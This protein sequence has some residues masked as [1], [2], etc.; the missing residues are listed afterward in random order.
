MSFQDPAVIHLLD[1]P[2]EILE[3][4]ISFTKLDYMR[5]ILRFVCKRFSKFIP[6]TRILPNKEMKDKYDTLKYF[7]NELEYSRIDG[8]IYQIMDK[9]K[10][11]YTVRLCKVNFISWLL[12]Q[13]FQRNVVLKKT[14]TDIGWIIKKRQLTMST[15]RFHNKDPNEYIKKDKSYLANPT[16]GDIYI[17]PSIQKDKSFLANTTKCETSCI[18]PSIQKYKN[19]QT[20]WLINFENN[21]FHYDTIYN[22]KKRKYDYV[23]KS[24]NHILDI[25]IAW[26]NN[27]FVL[28][29]DIFGY[30]ACTVFSLDVIKNDIVLQQMYDTDKEYSSICT[31][32]SKKY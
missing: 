19:N 23:D 14:E 12:K 1:I 7:V 11:C 18:I 2:T 29:H 31:V 3:I 24:T 25:S 8:F 13:K 9:W 17:I 15:F 5:G 28:N 30:P 4:I 20:N 26:E 32:L 6:P 10:N 27:I 22:L 21:H 16:K